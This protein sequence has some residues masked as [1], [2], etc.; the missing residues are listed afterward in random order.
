MDLL[1]LLKFDIIKFNLKEHTHVSRHRQKPT[2]RNAPRTQAACSSA[3]P[4]HRGGDAKVQSQGAAIS[5]ADCA[6]AS[7]AQVNNFSVA[8]KNLRDFKTTGVVFL[9]PWDA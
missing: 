4:Q 6:I 8:T 3:W 9:N 1:S 5:F 7:I 2:R